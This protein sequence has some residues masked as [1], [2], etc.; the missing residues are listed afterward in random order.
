MAEHLKD[1]NTEQ[2]V[3]S[4]MGIALQNSA[5]NFQEA[6]R[7]YEKQLDIARE[8]RDDRA[9]GDAYKSLAYIYTTSE[10]FQEAIECH[11]KY[12]QI[13]ERL[14]ETK[15]MK[16]TYY[17]LVSANYHIGNYEEAI[18]YT[19]KVLKLVLETGDK[20]AESELYMYYKMLGVCYEK[21][22]DYDEAIRYC[23]MCLDISKEIPDKRKE[24]ERMNH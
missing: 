23:K 9:A 5:G 10:R 14:H 4:M 16:A 18:E 13:V 1:I 2:L 19:K 17:D 12:L 15:E 3:G 20:E 8:N 22:N 6:I 21:L 11:K 24:L 7:C